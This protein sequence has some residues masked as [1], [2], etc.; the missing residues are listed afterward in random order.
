M[1]ARRRSNGD[2]KDVLILLAPAN[3]SCCMCFPFLPIARLRTF[4]PIPFNSLASLVQSSGHD[5]FLDFQACYW[6][7]FWSELTIRPYNLSTEIFL[8]L[9]VATEYEVSC[10][11]LEA[12]FG[13]NAREDCFLQHRGGVSSRLT[14]RRMASIF[15]SCGG[16]EGI[17][18]K[19]LRAQRAGQAHLPDLEDSWTLAM[20]PH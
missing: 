5:P 15:R 19:M 12:G 6:D 20:L 1:G 9:G 18:Q 2:K 13:P 3:S 16:K 10:G 8:R 7:Y 14:D 4:S 11:A 17:A